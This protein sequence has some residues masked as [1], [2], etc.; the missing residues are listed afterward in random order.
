MQN[1]NKVKS[2][3]LELEASCRFAEVGGMP[4]GL[5]EGWQYTN[6]W[7]GQAG[8]SIDPARD[9]RCTKGKEDRLGRPLQKGR[10]QVLFDDIVPTPIVK[11]S[12]EEMVPVALKGCKK[13]GYD[14]RD[15]TMKWEDAFIL[16]DSGVEI[17][18][19]LLRG[20]TTNLEMRRVDAGRVI[21]EW[22]AGR[23]PEKAVKVRDD[24]RRYTKKSGE[25]V[26]K[27]YKR[28]RIE[29]S[30]VNRYRPELF[31]DKGFVPF[32]PTLPLPVFG[33]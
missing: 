7:C 3:D 26:E 30:M 21:R 19:Y 10:G 14:N 5:G 13:N 28:L 22:N 2:A 9:G 17:W 15:L 25:V 32:N 12:I 4:A 18:V 11:G 6:R 16:A 33:L 29:W 8:V 31:T 27:V 23:L 20:N 24:I 1:G